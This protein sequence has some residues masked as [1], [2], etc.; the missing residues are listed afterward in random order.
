MKRSASKTHTKGAAQ[1]SETF[2]IEL[3]RQPNNQYTIEFA[4]CE[5]DRLPLKPVIGK[6]SISIIFIEAPGI[7]KKVA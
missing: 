5:A 1:P 4:G 7:Q 2:V 6:T 3:L